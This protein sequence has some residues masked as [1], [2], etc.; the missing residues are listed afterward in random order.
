MAGGPR[1][2]YLISQSSLRD[3]LRRL[4]DDAASRDRRI[5]FRGRLLDLFGVQII[6]SDSIIA[7][8]SWPLRSIQVSMIPT[9]MKL[10]AFDP[11]VQHEI[12]AEFQAKLLSFRRAT[13][14]AA[15]RLEFDA[16]Q[17]TFELRDL[18][19]SVAAATPDDVELRAE[20]F[21]LL[22]DED[23][24]IRDQRWL[25]LDGVATEAITVAGSESSGGSRYV[26]EIA[27][28]AQGI[29]AGRGEKSTIDPG[30][31]G[32]ALKRLGFPTEPRDARGKKLKLTE[33]VCA[34][35]R[36]LARDFGVPEVEDDGP[37]EKG[38]LSR[39]S[40]IEPQPV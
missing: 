28:I 29:L 37:A 35:A 17:F 9:G 31:F 32:K 16:S 11:E 2:T 20:V 1:F 10:P 40:A 27:E 7:V 8:D 38:G 14:G 26:S 6:Y 18:A 12:T 4:L 33:A 36:Q 23:A 5:P 25:G 30:L 34:R 13:L 24:E 22:R 21:N 3:K 15:R 39:G 19:C